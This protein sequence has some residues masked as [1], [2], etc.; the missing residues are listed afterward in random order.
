MGLFSQFRSQQVKTHS[1][2]DLCSNQHLG[3]LDSEVQDSRNPAKTAGDL[4]LG[5]A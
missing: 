5:L 3:L 4:I 1:S 2:Q